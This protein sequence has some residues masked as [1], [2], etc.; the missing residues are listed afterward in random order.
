PPEPLCCA[1]GEPETFLWI[2]EPCT[3]ISPDTLSPSVESAWAK[4]DPPAFECTP[5]FEPS[6]S[7]L[8]YTRTFFDALM[9]MSPAL[10]IL[11]TLFALS[12]TILFFFVWSTIVTFSWPSLSSKITRCPLRDLIIFVLFL[13]DSLFSGGGSRWFHSEPITIGRL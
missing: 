12:R 10:S 11:T 2:C 5:L 1:T 3:A 13:P 4:N 8:E 9:T 6:L 7:A